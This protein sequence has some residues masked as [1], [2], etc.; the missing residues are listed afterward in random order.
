MKGGQW[1]VITVVE[2]RDSV[3]RIC[4]GCPDMGALTH[5]A[6]Y[7]HQHARGWLSVSLRL[8]AEQ[9]HRSEEEKRRAKELLDLVQRH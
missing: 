5:R 4:V 9:P 6:L 1:S 3:T 7:E 2:Q 8:E